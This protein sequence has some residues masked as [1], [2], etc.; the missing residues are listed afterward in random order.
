MSETPVNQI[1]LALGIGIRVRTESLEH[2]GESYTS[3]SISA[4]WYPLATSLAFFKP[5]FDVHTQLA[6]ITF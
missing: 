4:S 2:V 5:S 3:V 6:V 1:L